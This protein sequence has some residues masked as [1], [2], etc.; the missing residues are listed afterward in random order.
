MLKVVLP[1]PEIGWMDS[2]MGGELENEP[3]SKKK[4]KVEYPFNAN[5]NAFK[6]WLS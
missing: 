5:L 4:R 6:D 3:I 1:E 2:E